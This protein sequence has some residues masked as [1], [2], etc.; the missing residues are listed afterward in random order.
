MK[1]ML[2]ELDYNQESEG[3][4][5]F[6]SQTVFDAYEALQLRLNDEHYADGVAERWFV[7]TSNEYGL[8]ADVQRYV[9]FLT[10]TIEAY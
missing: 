7:L 6:V 5:M 2:I 4:E 10:S 1:F 8:F 3:E 9:D